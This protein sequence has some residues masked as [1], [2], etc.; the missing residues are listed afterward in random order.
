VI[1]TLHKEEKAPANPGDLRA[2]TKIIA[3][4]Q[5]GRKEVRTVDK[6]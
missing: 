6:L 5:K 1:K 3:I 2:Y 4:K